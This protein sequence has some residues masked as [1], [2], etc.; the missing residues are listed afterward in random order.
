MLLVSVLFEGYVP[1]PDGRGVGVTVL[2]EGQVPFPYAETVAAKAP[3]K[4]MRSVNCMVCG[5]V[6]VLRCE[7]LGRL[8]NVRWWSGM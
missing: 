4:A 7:L 6:G 5:C 8:L 1:L 3:K 2:L